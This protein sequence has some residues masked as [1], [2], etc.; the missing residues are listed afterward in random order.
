MAIEPNLLEY[1]SSL[2]KRMPELASSKELVNLGIF[3]SEVALCVAR[4][5]GRGPTFIKFSRGRIRY[6][7]ASIIKFLTDRIKEGG[8]HDK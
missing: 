5:L 7:R 8:C 3:S 4:K 2:E 1:L 6:P